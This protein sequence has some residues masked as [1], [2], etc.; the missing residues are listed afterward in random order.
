MFNCVGTV[1]KNYYKD[2]WNG[3]YFYIPQKYARPRGDIPQNVRPRVSKR[4]RSRLSRRSRSR[5][6]RR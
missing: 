2:V 1:G 4:S 5:V 3:S 6:F